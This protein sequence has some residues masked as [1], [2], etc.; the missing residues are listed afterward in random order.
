MN[1]ADFYSHKYL[2][3][4]LKGVRVKASREAFRYNLFKEG[5]DIFGAIC[6]ITKDKNF[7]RVRR[8]GQKCVRTYHPSFWEKFE[9]QEAKQTI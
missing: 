8:D 6:G 7:I 1:S 5:E 3:S 2:N 9:E 4:F